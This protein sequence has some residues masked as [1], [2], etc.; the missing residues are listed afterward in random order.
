MTEKSDESMSKPDEM[1]AENPS[2]SEDAAEDSK[3]E[4]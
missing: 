4:K 1:S 2:A 3:E